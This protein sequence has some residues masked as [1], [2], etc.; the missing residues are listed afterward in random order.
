MNKYHYP[1][2]VAAL[3]FA[4]GTAQ[5]QTVRL[6]QIVPLSGPLANVGK[7]INSA[8]L[9]A[10]SQHNEGSR[11]KIELTTLDD[12]NRPEKSAEAV[13]LLDSKVMALLS[14][15][16]TVSCMA[17]KSAAEP[18]RLPL[19]APIAGAPQLRGKAAPFVFAARASATEELTRILKFCQVLGFKNVAVVVQDDNFGQAYLAALI[20]LLPQ[21]NMVADLSAIINPQ[22]P[23]YAHAV[24][25]LNQKPPNALIMLANSAHS[26][27]FFK[28][29]REKTPMPFVLNL[30]G[31]ANGFFASNLKGYTGAA[32][33][34][35]TTPSPWERKLLI[36]RDYQAAMQSVGINTYSYLSFEAYINARIAIEAIKRSKDYTPA[37]IKNTLDR[38]VFAFDTLVWRF[39]PQASTRYT[40]ISVLLADGNFRH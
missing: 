22:A 6:G 24:D 3:L 36:Q 13:E 9:A 20:A 30:A 40:D 11:L 17:Q 15:F 10:L 18:L 23:D 27:G 33:F 31:Q 37:G 2:L 19:I 28:A 29:W 1:L 8:T 38:G 12:S 4:C 16:G 7:E 5:P 34:V 39:G 32:A 21:Y 25:V 14:C 26:V 35:T